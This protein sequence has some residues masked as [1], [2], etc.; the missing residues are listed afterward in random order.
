MEKIHIGALQKDLENKVQDNA[1]VILYE[2]KI[3]L[4]SSDGLDDQ[5]IIHRIF[6][7][8]R[9]MDTTVLDV[10]I[11]PEEQRGRY[12]DQ[13]V[14]KYPAARID[15]EYFLIGKKIPTELLQMKSL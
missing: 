11:S 7:N 13:R 1:V 6:D 3:Q 4:I 15:G 9:E 5:L 8:E 14:K 10:V 2:L 12:L